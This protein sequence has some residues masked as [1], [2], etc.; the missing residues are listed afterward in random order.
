MTS[1]RQ[2]LLALCKKAI[3]EP[4]YLEVIAVLCCKRSFASKWPLFPV[5]SS[6]VVGRACIFTVMPHHEPGVL[7]E[8]WPLSRGGRVWGRRKRCW[9][10]VEEA[11][12]VAESAES[13]LSFNKTFGFPTGSGAES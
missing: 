6:I 11:L 1:V 9:E 4:C 13:S 8:D 2:A 5:S 12:T 7:R 3:F 10:R